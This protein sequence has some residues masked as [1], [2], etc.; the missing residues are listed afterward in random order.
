MA[1]RCRVAIALASVLAASALLI[2][3][4]PAVDD[5]DDGDTPDDPETVRNYTNHV[6]N[7]PFTTAVPQKWWDVR[8]EWTNRFFQNVLTGDSSKHDD[9]MHSCCEM[10]NKTGLRPHESW[11]HAT[12]SQINWWVENGCNTM[13]GA[14]VLSVGAP[15]CETWKF[16]QTGYVS[17]RVMHFDISKKET[18]FFT[19]YQK[20]CSA[21]D[22]QKINA[23]VTMKNPKLHMLMLP[24]CQV[25]ERFTHEGK[26]NRSLMDGC[27]NKF[28]GGLS[29]TC[30]F[31]FSRT[32]ALM[33]ATGDAVTHEPCMS[34][35][36]GLGQCWGMEKCVR[37]AG[38]CTRCFERQFLSAEFCIGG[39]TRVQL[40]GP[41]ILTSMMGFWA[42]L[43]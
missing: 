28:F 10:V 22:R 7:A 3:D 41:S 1:P 9:L 38:N 2:E 21:E 13:V 4:A 6:L 42:H 32:L 8:S 15:L 11:G 23:T 25:T 40:N 26:L 19:E 14:T 16:V 43:R 39:P 12:K 34:M 17:E 5:V 29:P 36:A 37:A 30:P 18:G 33:S 24:E 20:G 27:I 31:C 35:C